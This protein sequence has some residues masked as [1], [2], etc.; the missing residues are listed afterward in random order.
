MY[1]SYRIYKAIYQLYTC[2]YV[3]LEACFMLGNWHSDIIHIIL[4]VLMLNKHVGINNTCAACMCGI[5]ELSGARVATRLWHRYII[6][7][8]LVKLM[9]VVYRVPS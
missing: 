6:T 4:I 2:M 7:A 1:T 8:F 9:R 5:H 3:L